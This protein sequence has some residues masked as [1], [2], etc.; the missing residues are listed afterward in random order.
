MNYNIRDKRKQTHKD[1]ENLKSISE[2][3]MYV[4]ENYNT[5]VYRK[6]KQT[7]NLDEKCY[8]YIQLGKIV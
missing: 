5:H 4:L 1:L 7:S 8:Y 2:D 3:H 6:V